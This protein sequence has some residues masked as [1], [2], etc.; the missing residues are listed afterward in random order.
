MTQMNRRLSGHYALSGF[1]YFGSARLANE[2]NDKTAASKTS[3][4]A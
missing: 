1:E 4:E 3:K 2:A